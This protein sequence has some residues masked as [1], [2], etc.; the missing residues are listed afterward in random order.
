MAFTT[1]TVP[2]PFAS[3][4]YLPTFVGVAHI[5]W[6]PRPDHLPLAI[7]VDRELD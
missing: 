1:R 2:C 7:L 6:R 4:M 3:T 5:L